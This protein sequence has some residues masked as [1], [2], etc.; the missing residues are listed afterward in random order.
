MICN[1]SNYLAYS[2]IIIGSVLWSSSALPNQIIKNE[3]TQFG[4]IIAS[5][6]A[7]KGETFDISVI[8]SESG[9][10]KIKNAI[11]LIFRKSP[12]NTKIIR[13]LSKFGKILVIYDP[14]FP[15]K[16]LASQKIAAF[17]PD[18]YQHEGDIKQFRVVVGRYGIKWPLE[19]LAAV[20]VHE[21]AGHGL[22]HLRKRTLSDRKIDRECEALIYEEKAYQDFKILRNTPDR[23]NFL[24]DMRFRWCA[25]FNWYLTKNNVNTDQAWGYGRPDVI[26]LL[27]LFEKYIDHL[28]KTGISANAV[29]ASKDKRIDN[30]EKLKKLA[31]S[32]NDFEG[33]FLIGN[34]YLTGIGVKRNFAQARYWFQKAASWGHA[35]ALFLLGVLYERGLGV[36]TNYAQAYKWFSLSFENGMMKAHGK[37]TEMSLKLSNP[38]LKLSTKEIMNWRN[39]INQNSQRLE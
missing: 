39:L 34:R 26:K 36:K 21:L 24:N 4:I 9:N 23:R 17:F 16:Q 19:R 5:I 38:D 2:L 32:K 33:F 35:N 25:D 18:F 12:F 1:L 28:R 10:T 29:K 20:L 11:E 31:I 37:K 8:D 14:S 3:L 27:G 30:F 15:K 13:R 22:Q 6:S 7:K